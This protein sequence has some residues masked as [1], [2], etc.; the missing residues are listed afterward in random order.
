MEPVPLSPA[1]ASARPPAPAQ[2]PS[3]FVPRLGAPPLLRP[4][5][6]RWARRSRVE[7]ARGCSG[8]Q[9]HITVRLSHTPPTPLRAATHPQGRMCCRLRR[10]SGARS[11]CTAPCWS[12]AGQAPPAGGRRLPLRRCRCPSRAPSE[13][14]SGP[15]CPGCGSPRARRRPRRSARGRGGRS[16]ARC[17]GCRRG[18]SRVQLYGTVY[19]IEYDCS[20]TSRYVRVCQYVLRR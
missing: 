12:V 3:A 2:P 10:R 5:L 1:A 13:R 16:S 4:H 8:R 18:H 11:M 7:R 20:A 9:R 19:I 6:R 17:G 14:R 15:T